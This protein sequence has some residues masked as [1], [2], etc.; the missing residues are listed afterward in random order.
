MAEILASS[1]E[2]G[3][4]VVR[5]MNSSLSAKH[6]PGLGFF[7]DVLTF[8]PGEWTKS[9]TYLCASPKVPFIVNML[10]VHIGGL[11]LNLGCGHNR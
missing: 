6:G 9:F 3:A 11:G 10:L 5:T 2:G 4:I 7:P 1:S 8:T